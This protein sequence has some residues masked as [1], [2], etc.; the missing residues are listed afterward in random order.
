MQESEKLIN[1]FYSAF[2]KKDWKEMQQ[3]YHDNVV[4][5][6]AVFRNLKGQEAKA[7]WHMLA[8]A[9]K[10]LEVAYTNVKTDGVIGSCEWDARYSFSLTGRKVHNIIHAAFEFSEGKIIRHKDSF[11]LWKWSGMALGASGKLLGWTPFIQ[12]KIRNTAR[13]NLQRFIAEHPE[14]KS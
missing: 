6:D 10:D 8:I 2:Q 13:R 4:F 1:R 3:C 7:M 11:N 14:Y 5:S 9:G 12:A